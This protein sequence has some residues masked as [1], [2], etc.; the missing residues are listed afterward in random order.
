MA[1]LGFADNSDGEPITIT[2]EFG[3]VEPLIY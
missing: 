1:A 2:A 3:R